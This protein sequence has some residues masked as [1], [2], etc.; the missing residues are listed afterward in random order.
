MADFIVAIELRSTRITGIAGRKNLDGSISVMACAMEDSTSCIRKGV[1][2]NI[3]KTTQAITN[4]VGRLETTIKARITQVYVGVGGQSIRSVLNSH[5]KELTE[6]TIVT[7]EMVNELMDAN[8]SMQ[9][10]DQEIL[11]AVTQEYH[12]DQ[13]YQIDPVGIQ[14]RRLEGNFLNILWRRSFYRNL[15]KCFEQAG[16]SI[17]EMY[18]SPLA[19]ADAVLTDL[20]KRS[21]CVLVDL[22]AGTTTVAVYYKNILRNL[23]VI[24]LGGA[25]ITR[26]IES[27][28]LDEEEAEKVKIKYASAFT[29]SEDISETTEFAVDKERS[30]SQTTLVDVVEARVME[31]VGNVWHCIPEEYHD[32]LTGG[33][34]LTGG[35]VNLDNM[36]QAFREITEISKV[37]VA[38]MVT[39]KINTTNPLITTPDATMNTILGLLARG[40]MNCTGEPLHKDL[41]GTEPVVT[42]DN[43]P[44]GTP[45]V[46]S[47]TDVP[48]GT[49]KVKTAAERDAEIEARKREEAE[50]EAERLR[51]EE[52]RKQEEERKR[53]E[54]SVVHKTMRSLKHFFNTIVS[55]EEEEK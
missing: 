35:G 12:V 13:Q 21:G 20:E 53:K 39:Q 41:F 42:S 28:Q 18:L 50:R 16:V 27:L 4:I 45:T 23:T 46:A 32:K 31:I 55:A 6:E 19:L 47:R 7:Q 51:A 43:A 36:E 3:D 8:R 2:Y 26:D 44:A 34:V 38:R 22:G 33:F 30:I 1:V 54:N 25:N 52:E 49:G 15:N 5:S 24:P 10:P 14:C 40:D 37:R 9:Y 11:D 48:T 17:A 29:K